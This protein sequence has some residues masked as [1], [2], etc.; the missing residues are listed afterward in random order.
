MTNTLK[1]YLGSGDTLGRLRDHAQRL[2]RI[3]GALEHALPPAL[4][5][6]CS[7]ANL[8]GDTLVLLARDG[9]GAARLRQLL[10][11]LARKLG[12]SGHLVGKIQVRIGIQVDAPQRRPPPVR[13]LSSVAEESLESLK[14]SLPE[15]DPLREALQRLI[16]H[17]RK[18]E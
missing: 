10:P 14:H 16:E 8:K 9:A 6:Q 11:T 5:G 7:V 3:Q 18:Q 13:A 17:S 1:N 2:M 12:E 4:R 15:H